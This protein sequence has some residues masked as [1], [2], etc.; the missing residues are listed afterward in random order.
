MLKPAIKV[1]NWITMGLILPMGYE[2]W[3][4]VE[5]LDHSGWRVPLKDISCSDQ[6]NQGFMCHMA[7]T[8]I[9]TVARP[10]VSSF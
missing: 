10:G 6:G 7:A 2:R 9:Q 5:G 4:L 3:G 8:S 1:D